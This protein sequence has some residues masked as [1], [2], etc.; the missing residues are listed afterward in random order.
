[1][2][3]YPTCFFLILFRSKHNYELWNLIFKWLLYLF[4]YVYYFFQTFFSFG[5]W[6]PWFRYSLFTSHY[7]SFIYNFST[8]NFSL[9]FDHP[10]REKRIYIIYLSAHN[11]IQEVWIC[12]TNRI[13]I[14]SLIN[15]KKII[16]RIYFAK[17]IFYKICFS[18]LGCIFQ[19]TVLFNFGQ[20]QNFLKPTFSLYY[21]FMKQFELIWDTFYN[22][23]LYPHLLINWSVFV[24]FLQK[25]TNLIWHEV[26]LGQ[27]H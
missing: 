21:F 24:S 6:Q 20:F 25:M 17:I 10:F 26:L 16:M 13:D 3:H 22:F 7:S 18:H 27:N 19:G 11:I 4:W 9:Y 1:M 2:I 15:N 14:Y 23:L 12:F 8:S 5:K